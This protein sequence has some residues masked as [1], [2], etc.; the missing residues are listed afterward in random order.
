MALKR[1][2]KVA[3]LASC[4]GGA[5]AFTILGGASDVRVDVGGGE[6]VVF[7]LWLWA[8]FG[9]IAGVLFM[10]PLVLV[11][12]LIRRSDRNPPNPAK[13]TRWPTP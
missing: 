12:W 7:P 6:A 5:L 4:L 2:I 13:R 8:C 1:T 3:L 10:T 9:A 11:F